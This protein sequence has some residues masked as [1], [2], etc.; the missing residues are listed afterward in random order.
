[1]PHQQTQFAPGVI[2]ELWADARAL[3]V[4]GIYPKYASPA[5]VALDPD[6]PKRLAGAL[7]AAEMWRKYGDEDALFQW[8]RDAEAPRTPLW[9]RRTKAE[10]DELAEPKPPHVVTATDG[11]PPIRVPGTGKWRHHLDGR[12]VDLPH[13]T[14][15]L[16]RRQE[17]A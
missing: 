10:L 15:R 14:P 5:W 1:M 9:A 8:F 7:E 2:A 3:W 11:W 13:N 16:T 4:A 6:D 12:Q 17:A